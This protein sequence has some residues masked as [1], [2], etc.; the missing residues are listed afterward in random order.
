M[1]V[2]VNTQTLT[3]VKNSMSSRNSRAQKRGFALIVT[4]S[5]MI[6]LTIIAVGLLTLSSIS[7]RQAGLS[8]ATQIAQNN[9]RMALCIA[10]GELQLHAGVD[11][12]VTATAD[13]AGTDTGD[14]LPASAD[15]T[16]K[17]NLSVNGQEKGLSAIQPGTRYWTG[18]WNDRSAT[19]ATE[20]LTKTPS[21][22]LRQWLISGNEALAPASR[23]TP[24]A[25]EYAV[26][27]DG[28]VV[29]TSKAVVL[30]GQGS[31]G[32][33]AAEDLNRF[34]VAPLVTIEKKANQPEGRYA[35]WVGDE[36]VKAR[37]NME[38]VVADPKSYHSLPAQRRGWETVDGFATYPV[39]SSPGQ[40]ELPKVTSLLQARLLLP[41]A[42]D[43]L[44]K[45]FHSAT[46]DSK[47]VIAN[48][49]TGGTRVDL[50]P[51]LAGDLPTS[52]PANAAEIPNYPVRG[53]RII[54]TSSSTPREAPIWDTVN[55]FHDAYSQLSGGA[56]LVKPATTTRAPSIA[57]VVTDFR[58]LMGARILPPAG[59]PAATATNFRVHP[60]GKIAIAIANPYSVPLKWERDLE[61]EIKNQTP[62]GNNPSRIW[63][64]GGAGGPAFLPANPSEAAVFNST[65]FRI[66]ASSL[67]PGE[68]R[69]YTQSA[70]V[71]RR[72]GTGTSRIVI[73]MVPFS[74]ASAF[75]FA[76]CVE[77]ENT[78]MRT[79]P[80]TMDVRES[81]QTSL[82]MLEM[83][84]NGS[85]PSA[86]PL[87]RLERFE[88]D[89]GYFSPNQRTFSIDEARQTNLP[90][91]LMLYSFQISQPGGDYK[92]VMPSSYQMGQRGST[93][94]TFADF[95]VAG[96]RISKPI[97]SYN[98]PPYFMESNDS[99]SQLPSIVPGGDTGVAFTR[100][101]VSDPLPWGRG[102][103]GS[104][105]TIL[106]T[107]PPQISSLA[108]L[109]HADLTGDDVAGS[110]GH[111]P[112]NAFAN[113]YASPLVKRSLTFQNRVDYE[114]I[115]S[116]NPSGA[117]T[118]ARK[119][120]DISYLLNASTWD[121]FFLST[122]PKSGK[123]IPEIPSIA[124]HDGGDESS[125]LRDPMLAGGRLMINGAFN[126]NS[127]DK[128]AWKAFLASTKHF[129][130][131]ADSA[132][133][134]DAAF[135]RSLEQASAA[136][137]PNL[138][139]GTAEDSFAGF[140]R[141]SD[142]Q[143]DSLAT[144]ITRQVRL[145][146][147]FVS[148]SHFINRA[149]ATIDKQP[150][151]TRSGTLQAAADESGLNINFAG[152]KKSFSG[153]TSSVDA[154]TLRGAGSDGS[155]MADMAGGKTQNR[156]ASASSDS[157]WA[158][159]STDQNYGAVASIIADREMIRDSKFQS[160][161]GYR[162]TGIPGWLTQAD[163][164]QV[165]GPSI[166]SRSDTFRIRTYGE[167]L[168]AKGNVIAKAYCEAIVQRVPTYLDPTNL[169]SD[170]GTALTSTNKTYGRQL[171]V[172]SFR[173]LSPLEI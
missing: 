128:N 107:L 146:G 29:D 131:T 87:A 134:Q 137:N 100:N 102:P 51:I 20:I 2:N 48:T 24:A 56:L 89:N 27:S 9:A 64:M 150:A 144:E 10:L 172:I 18:V 17:N 59:T 75:N 40:A 58:I 158:P 77:L 52:K 108:Q 45:S 88:L 97:A 98:P 112:G 121:T 50:T 42:A 103:S 68:G 167:A 22:Q 32:N 99:R 44:K 173:W 15:S 148:L 165:I 30:V 91:P 155:P 122:I 86:Q 26:K 117:N 141:L 43:S 34:V 156:P 162:S 6:L 94:R 39:P 143:L 105:K 72:N 126:V 104:K 78:T 163:I 47:A 84:L 138:P 147:P 49:L 57:P 125:A 70:T 14:T 13:M 110:L 85:S 164:L 37:I 96:T 135:P 38:Q 60:C 46:A 95:N 12:R 136:T 66:R 7:I 170:R 113:S 109:Q 157:D 127:T 92:S 119:Y 8:S 111:Q 132:D 145:R 139:T 19:P 21:P 81:W 76:N 114:L 161:Q 11:Q 71:L 82:L 1:M 28:S 106:F 83:R 63:P 166:T 159:S 130:H 25:A 142:S 154:V 133:S 120:F 67:P 101:L 168:D 55:D 118:T 153:V 93:L 79:P 53:G 169:P 61:F 151:L 90:V 80:L 33:T 16:P 115:G 36:G 31:V 4:L 74:T 23:I 123:P 116:P 152:D 149:L 73:D 160:E 35:W 124:R 54:P 5:L 41:N 65:I 69:A 3:S 171:Q 140:R 129:K 62:A